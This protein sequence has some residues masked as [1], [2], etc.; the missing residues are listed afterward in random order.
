MMEARESMLAIL[1][2][3][4]DLNGWNFLNDWNTG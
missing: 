2:P 4:H 3:S 1:S